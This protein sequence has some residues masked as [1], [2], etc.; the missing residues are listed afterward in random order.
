MPE[1]VEQIAEPPQEELGTTA[2]RALWWSVAN[3]MVGR[4]GTTL[5]GIVLARIL[6]PEDYGVYA[7][8]LVALNTLWSMN[9]LGVSLAVVRWPGDPGRIAPTVQTLALGSSVLLWIAIFA[10]APLVASALNTPD[11][12]W[13]VR[14]LT[15]AV[16]IDAITAVPAALMT[17]EFMQRERMIVDTVGFGVGFVA[18]IV[19]A[20]LG[21]G[22]WALVASALLGNIVNALFIVRYAPKRYRYG[23]DLGIAK[24]LLAFGL[25][26]AVASLMMIAML[27]IDYVVIGAVLGPIQ[28]GFYL[29]AFNLSAWPVNM[30]SAPARRISLPLFAR[31]HAGE[32][33][34]S[35]AFVPVC[36]ALLLVTLP[37]CLM[38]AVFAE[39]IVRTVYG[40]TWAAAAAALPWL[41]VL[42]IARVLGELVYDF[43]V[44]LGASRTNL[45]VQ[46]IWFVALLAALPIAAH[47][48]GIEAVAMAHAGVA[49]MIVIPAYG[50]A[51][52]RSGVSLRAVAGQLARPVAGGALAAAAG[53]VIA[54]WVGDDLLALV[55]GCALVGLVYGAV[56]YPMRA[57]LKASAVTTA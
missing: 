5:M 43:L 15:L 11:A 7:V 23:W 21:A 30:F 46:T 34:A 14:I 28:L 55:I 1:T 40:D 26:L 22:P 44:A 32:T 54:L 36:A 49:M 33:S 48:G 9:E 57:I 37:A 53:V 10:C 12:V 6:V 2:R 17:R 52:A 42:A 19:M 47:Q 25:P 56:V 41:M 20:V 29:L 3:N 4:V 13:L 27:N 16:L 8:A 35:A 24:E 18:A 31:L 38:L 50:V 39:P 45:V 51:L